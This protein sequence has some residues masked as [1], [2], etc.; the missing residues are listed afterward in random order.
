MEF[1]ETKAP[2]ICKAEYW[3]E[4]DRENKSERERYPGIYREVF[5]ILW[6]KTDQCM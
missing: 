3:E 2:R 5:T 6:V 4:A 1:R